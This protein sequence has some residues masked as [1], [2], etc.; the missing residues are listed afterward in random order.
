MGGVLL[1]PAHCGTAQEG[2]WAV[3]CFTT[4]TFP[5]SIPRPFFLYVAFH[6]PH[7]CGHSQPQY[8]T[9]CEKFGNGESGMG[10]IPDWQ[11]QIFQ[12]EE[13]QVR[14]CGCVWGS[15]RACGGVWGSMGLH[16]METVLAPPCHC[17]QCHSKSC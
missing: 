4:C 13:V 15:V 6:D 17:L 2:L 9:F 5:L 1:T 3:L 16:M 7:R 14:A 11:P 8:G 12:P 10:W